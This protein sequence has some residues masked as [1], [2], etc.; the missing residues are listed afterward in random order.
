MITDKTSKQWQYINAS[1]RIK[2]ENGYLM[3]GEYIGVALGSYFGEIG[4]KYIFIRY[5][6]TN[7]SC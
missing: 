2:I 1:G 6:Q 4:T 7:K 3:E 5:R